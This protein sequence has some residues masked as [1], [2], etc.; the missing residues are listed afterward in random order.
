[1]ACGNNNVSRSYLSSQPSGQG[2]RDSVT[3]RLAK[4]PARTAKAATARLTKDYRSVRMSPSQVKAAADKRLREAQKATRSGQFPRAPQF[5]N[6]KRSKRYSQ[7]N[8]HRPNE[9]ASLVDQYIGPNGDPTFSKAHVHVFHDEKNDEVR[10]HVSLGETNRHSEKIAL[11]GATGNEVNAA[12]DLL[13]D[14][15]RARMQ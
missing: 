4:G 11:V 12:V 1:M 2:V 13:T 9:S 7:T 10:L 6:E 5:K 3:A 14:A 15:L 8:K